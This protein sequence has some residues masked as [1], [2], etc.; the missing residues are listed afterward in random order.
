MAFTAEVRREIGAPVELVY[1]AWTEPDQLAN[2]F[3][4][5]PATYQLDVRP[6]GT[7]HFGSQVIGVGG[8]FLEVEPRRRLTYTWVWD[9]AETQTAVCAEFH[10]TATGTQL[11]VVHTDNPD[12]QARDNHRQ[13]WSDCIDRLEPYLAR[14]G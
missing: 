4:P 14:R 6:G 10:P 11:R 12:T 7:F 5:F 8:R 2:W 9:D 3:W 1:A 13:G